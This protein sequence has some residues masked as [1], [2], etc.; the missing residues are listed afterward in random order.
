MILTV[1]FFSSIHLLE[2][3][4]KLRPVEEMQFLVVYLSTNKVPLFFFYFCSNFDPKMRYN[5]L[6]SFHIFKLV[7]L[8]PISFSLFLADRFI[9]TFW[10]KNLLWPVYPGKTLASFVTLN[11][12]LGTTLYWLKNIYWTRRFVFPFWLEFNFP[13]HL[14]KGL[15]S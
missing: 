10:N 2:L 5:N 3:W 15:L 7:C 12:S 8:L 13:L 11:E 14:L 6:Y 1:I 9:L 4:E